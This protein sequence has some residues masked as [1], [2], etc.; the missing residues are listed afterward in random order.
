MKESELRYGFSVAGFHVNSN[1]HTSVDFSATR[2]VSP[3][4]SDADVHAARGKRLTDLGMCTSL[5]DEADR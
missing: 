5:V 4:G 2:P 3:T 1:T